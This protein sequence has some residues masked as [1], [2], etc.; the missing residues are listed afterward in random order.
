M[1]GHA[2][3]I[4]NISFNNETFTIGSCYSFEIFIRDKDGQKIHETTIAEHEADKIQAVVDQFHSEMNIVADKLSNQITELNSDVKSFISKVVPMVNIE[5]FVQQLKKFIN[6]MIQQRYKLKEKLRKLLAKA[7]IINEVIK[8]WFT[9]RDGMKIKGTKYTFSYDQLDNIIEVIKENVIEYQYMW[10]YD[11][12]ICYS[13]VRQDV[14]RNRELASLASAQAYASRYLKLG[15]HL[16]AHD[17]DNDKLTP[18]NTSFYRMNGNIQTV[19]GFYTAP[20]FGGKN[21]MIG[22]RKLKSRDTMQSY[23]GIGDYST[24]RTNRGSDK[25]IAVDNSLLTLDQRYQALTKGKITE[26]NYWIASDKKLQIYIKFKKLMSKYLESIR[27]QQSKNIGLTSQIVSKLWNSVLSQVS[28]ALD[29]QGA[30]IQEY[31]NNHQD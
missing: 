23:Y 25:K 26:D 6:M 10:K 13:Y 4:R 31:G 27:A 2:T 29:P 24:R 15:Y 19:I 14:K 22:Q 30:R 5:A 7:T 18:E 3:T 28:R 16:E 17:L 8:E 11:R 20:G 12:K 21:K 9:R 1:E